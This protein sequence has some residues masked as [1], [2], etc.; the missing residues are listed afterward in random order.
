MVDKEENGNKYGDGDRFPQIMNVK[1][2]QKDDRWYPPKDILREM[3]ATQGDWVAWEKK[4]K[5]RYFI[6]VLNPDLLKKIKISERSGE[7][8]LKELIKNMPDEVPI[9]GVNYV[10]Q[11]KSH[12]RF[13]SKSQLSRIFNEIGAEEDDFIVLDYVNNEEEGCGW[14]MSILKNA[15]ILPDKKR[16]YMET[17]K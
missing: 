2:V 16:E 1:D 5:H 4:D 7:D 6:Y 3:G 10:I 11:V 13:G 8:L 14:Y 15:E 12:G 9:D 17:G